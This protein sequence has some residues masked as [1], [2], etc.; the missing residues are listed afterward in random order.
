MTATVGRATV[1]LFGKHPAWPD[2]LT[3]PLPSVGLRDLWQELY[4]G[5]V[6]FAIEHEAWADAAVPFGHWVVRGTAGDWTLGRVWA[7]ADAVGRRD[8]PLVAAVHWPGVDPTRLVD[9]AGPALAALETACRATPFA[10]NVTAAVAG[11]ERHLQ[12]YAPAA[13]V[14]PGR[15]ATVAGAVAGLFRAAPPTAAQAAAAALAT[16]AALALAADPRVAGDGDRL[17]ACAAAWAGA[18]VAPP[19]PWW[20]VGTGRRPNAAPPVRVPRGEGSGLAVLARWAGFAAAAAG[21]NAVTFAAIADGTTWVDLFV[22]DGSIDAFVRLRLD[23]RG[24][25]MTTFGVGDG[26]PV[27]IR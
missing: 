1:G 23:L 16:P 20:P 13:S 5:G 9:A 11:A 21:P 17:P 24:R 26:V 19:R 18:G 27:P 25:P 12:R 14:E 8:Y 7:S 2:H 15:W 6:R 22:G 3:L 4:T 10:A